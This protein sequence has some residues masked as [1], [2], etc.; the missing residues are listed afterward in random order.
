MS[1]PNPPPIRHASLDT[2]A[3]HVP[4][5]MAMPEPLASAQRQWAQADAQLKEAQQQLNT[6]K[7]EIDA[8]FAK[9]QQTVDDIAPRW[10]VQS[11]TALSGFSS[12][13]SDISSIQSLG[14]AFPIVF[15]VVA[16]M[17]SLTT[18]SRLVE[19]RAP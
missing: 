19:C 11:R 17:M 1:N 7:Q 15:L 14:N 2:Q 6:K 12:L 13:K 16:V 4:V 5:G 9:E 18:M 10:Y 3:A 8:R